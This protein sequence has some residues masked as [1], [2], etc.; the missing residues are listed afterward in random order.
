MS[1]LEERLVRYIYSPFTLG[2]LLFLLIFCMCLKRV[3][4]V[5]QVGQLQAA[6][7][8]KWVS[9]ESGVCSWDGF[10]LLGLWAPTSFLDCYSTAHAV[11]ARGC[12]CVG[13]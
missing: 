11:K 6:A 5:S 10:G 9:E 4:S 7:R 13:C 2:L 12:W 3:F 1:C 8:E